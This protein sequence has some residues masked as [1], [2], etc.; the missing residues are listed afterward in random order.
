MSQG[1]KAGFYLKAVFW[2][3]IMVLTPI[4]RSRFKQSKISPL[5]SGFW[6]IFGDKYSF[7]QRISK[8]YGNGKFERFDVFFKI[9]I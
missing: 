5:V 1:R 6:G 7:S 9:K 2:L 3:G 4:S 8:I